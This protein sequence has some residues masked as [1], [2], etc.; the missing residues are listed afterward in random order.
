M[1]VPVQE[2][3]YCAYKEIGICIYLPFSDLSKD[4]HEHSLTLFEIYRSH[5]CLFLLLWVDIKEPY[6]RKLEKL[7]MPLLQNGS[8]MDK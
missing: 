4:P 5:W 2:T 6:A 3:W 7:V 8:I 1:T